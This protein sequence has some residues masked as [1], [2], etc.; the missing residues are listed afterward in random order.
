MVWRTRSINRVQTISNQISW[1]MFYKVGCAAESFSKALLSRCPYSTKYRNLLPHQYR[2]MMKN[3]KGK[4][5][6]ILI[7]CQIF[8]INCKKCH[9]SSISAFPASKRR[10]KH[11]LFE[12]LPRCILTIQWHHTLWCHTTHHPVTSHFVM[13]HTT[14]YPVTS[15]FVMSHHS[16]VSL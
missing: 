2:N 6:I 8:G 16:Q 4:V 7:R 14:H 11:H 12:R 13:S 3:R 10:L 1:L 15:H 5:R 9:L